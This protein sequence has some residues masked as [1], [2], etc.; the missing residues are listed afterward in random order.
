MLSEKPK[1]KLKNRWVARADK[2]NVIYIKQTL[3]FI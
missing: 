3:N 2:G 1:T